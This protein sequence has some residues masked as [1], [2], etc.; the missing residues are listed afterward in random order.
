MKSKV[1]LILGYILLVSSC[2]AL[3][4]GAMVIADGNE[5]NIASN[6]PPLVLCILLCFCA[7]MLIRSARRQLLG[8]SSPK[9]R[10]KA[11]GPVNPY[12]DCSLYDTADSLP[13]VNYPNLIL[14]PGEMLYFA[15]LANTF[16][17]KEQVIGY[18]GGSKGISVRV[19]KGL[20]YRTGG[21]RSTAIRGDVIK[22]NP[23][24]Y[25]VTNQRLIFIGMKDAFDIPLS[26]VT[27][28]KPIARDAFTILAGSKQKNVKTEVNQ[29]V[30]ALGMTR[31]AIEDFAHGGR[32][33]KDFTGGAATNQ[34]PAPGSP[35]AAFRDS[36]ADLRSA[37]TELNEYL[38]GDS[39]PDSDIS[40]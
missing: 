18:S 22:Y 12:V 7:I 33:A 25:I 26:K 1:K 13:P 2:I 28:V 11:S 17:A 4:G 9:K 39:Q 23:G 24:D 21:S 35:E 10:K 36:L 37:V 20:T 30:Y 34:E 5:E 3:L 29:T 14:A 16:T 31:Q 15:A 32:P 6:I 19:A 38:N 8:I 27:A 40:E